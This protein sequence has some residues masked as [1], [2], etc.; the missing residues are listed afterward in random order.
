MRIGIKKIYILENVERLT[1]RKKKKERKINKGRE[2]RE[3]GELNR[4]I[5]SKR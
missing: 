4:R 2:R 5:E 3:T 1:E